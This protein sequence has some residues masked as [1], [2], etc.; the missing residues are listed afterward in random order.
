MSNKAEIN[1]IRVALSFSRIATYEVATKITVADDPS[2]LDLYMWNA[3]VSGALLTPLHI[4]EVV[5]R[6]AVSD[7]LEMVYGSRWPWS[8]VFELSLPN[9]AQGYNQRKDLLRARKAAQ[10]TGKVIPELSFVFWQKMFTSRHDIR[11][12]DKNLKQVF[13]NMDG[14]KTSYTQLLCMERSRGNGVS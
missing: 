10:T 2:A 11:L 13:V 12:W 7:V 9:P 3:E 6:N 1:A 14:T 4:C 5:I 8:Q